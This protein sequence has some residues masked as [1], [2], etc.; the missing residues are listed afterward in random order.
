MAPSIRG[1]LRTF[2]CSK[3]F[4]LRVLRAIFATRCNHPHATLNVDIT[5][6]SWWQLLTVTKSRTNRRKLVAQIGC[7]PQ[8]IWDVVV[9]SAA[10]NAAKMSPVKNHLCKRPLTPPKGTQLDKLTQTNKVTNKRANPKGECEVPN[11]LPTPVEIP[12][13]L[14][15]YL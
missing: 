15:I 13:L 2:V 10:K 8:A 1:A 9:N 4:L 14:Q 12:I 3:D 11:P 6:F 7:S 5:L